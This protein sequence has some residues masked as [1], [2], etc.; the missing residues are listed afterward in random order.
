MEYADKDFRELAF[1]L[2][3]ELGSVLGNLITLNDV[4]D[5]TWR[6]REDMDNVKDEGIRV[7][8]KEFQRSVRILEQLMF[9]SMKDINVRF[10]NVININEAI[11]NI[12]VKKE[13]E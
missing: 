11:F 7:R 2:D 12:A 8:I 13:N 6:L 1:D 10:Q 4:S 9:Y 3:A 5:L